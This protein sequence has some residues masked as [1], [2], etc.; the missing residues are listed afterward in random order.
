[1]AKENKPSGYNYSR[2]WFDFALYN[3]GSVTGNHT[4]LYLWLVELNNRLKWLE[5]FGLTYRE[6]MDGMSCKSR[7][8]YNKCFKNLI[9]WGFIKIVKKSRNQY[10]ANI[11]ALSKNVQA[12]I[13]WQTKNCTTNGIS[14]GISNGTTN[15]ISNGTIPKTVKTNK[16]LNLINIYSQFEF[17]NDEFKLVWEQFILMRKKIKKAPTEHA[18]KLI[19][20]KI[21]NISNNN[22]LLAIQIVEQSILNNWQ[23]IF[24]LKINNHKNDTTRPL[25]PE[26]KGFGD[27]HADRTR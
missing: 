24:E 5:S 20:E 2:V 7:T 17:F 8:T 26:K 11:I 25:Q 4:A 23:G 13:I 10:E 18:E 22:I 15:G 19:L 21:K 3:P 1:M 16:Q 9:Q 27:L 14:N 12:K 6:G